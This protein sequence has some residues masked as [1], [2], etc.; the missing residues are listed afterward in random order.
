MFTV[1]KRVFSE[2]LCLVGFGTDF[3]SNVFEEKSFLV[4]SVGRRM[5]TDIFLGVL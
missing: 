3:F 1:E 4:G 5:E 2:A